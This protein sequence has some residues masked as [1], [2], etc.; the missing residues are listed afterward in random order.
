MP[1]CYFFEK[2]KNIYRAS[3]TDSRTR[4]FL[5]RCFAERDDGLGM[6][7]CGTMNVILHTIHGALICLCFLPRHKFI[8][9]V[10]SS[11]IARK[12]IPSGSVLEFFDMHQLITLETVFESAT[13]GDAA[14]ALGK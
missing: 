3:D 14:G 10:Y 13:F 9:S 8:Y 4:G 7:F 5:Q 2:T 11:V 6:P 1:L 12:P